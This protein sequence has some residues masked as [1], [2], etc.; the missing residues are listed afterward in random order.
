MIS[1]IDTGYKKLHTMNRR[2]FLLSVAK[3]VLLGGIITRLF[4]LQINENKKYLTLSDKN[5]LR[6]WKLPPTR[7]EFLDYFGNVVAGN[8]KV[9][10]LH[11]V[12]EQVENFKYLMLRLKDIL[13]LNENQFSKI[14]KKK[15]SQKPWETL[16]ISENLT[17]DQFSKVNFYLHELSGAKPVLSVARSY[18]YK[19]NYTHV[20]G[21]VS[22]ASQKDL[23]NNENIKNKHVPGLRVGKTG[24]EKKF[25]NEL[26]G[27][28]GVQRYE[29]NAYGK[30]INQVDFKEGEKGKIIRLTIDTEIQKF[31]NELLADKAGS[32]SVMD[33]FTG[34]II[35]MHSSPSFDPN[36][37]LYGISVENWKSIRENT[38]KPLINKTI[39]GLYSPGSTIKPIVALSALENNVI[40]PNFKV[41]CTG[42]T[43]LYGQTYHCW[44]EKGH[45]VVDLKNA[46]KKSCDTYFYEMSRRLGVD[47][48]NVTATRYGLGNKVFNDL[49]FEEKKG[50]VP[51]TKWK[52]DNL[53][54]G[55]VLGE[56]LITGIGQGYIQT[57][58]LQ[59]CLMTAQLANGGFKI[60]PRLTVE[61]D[62]ESLEKIKYKMSESLKIIEK[63]DSS[64]IRT[65]EKFFKPGEKKYDKLFRNQ[66]NVKFVLDA[67]FASTNEW[68]GTSYRSRIE[69]KKYQ[70]AGKT[71]TAQV[72]KI[73]KQER[74]LDLDTA[75]IPYEQRDH[76]WYIAFGPYKNPRYA[77]SILVEH[78]GAGSAAAAP[79]AKKLF[80]KI[81]DRHEER[82][83]IRKNYLNEI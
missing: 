37:F 76:A 31:C 42:K 47:R 77:L 51:S 80:K 60:F 41:R 58:P 49:Y 43:E 61:K 70:F 36:L 34:D 72:K 14:I 27:T 6:E 67:M 53:G 38:L 79:L 26:I 39:S 19:E 46:I 1:G 64:I 18:P 20:L 11:V 12:P 82:E 5:R 15:N 48:L 25:E 45:G 63:N 7:G 3:V 83:R 62:Q 66:E 9:Y 59:L 56:T 21:Y 54:R 22:Q 69:D 44:K 8:L 73:T 65:A 33:I 74:E 68:G 32:I 2:V 16:I 52:K 78:G 28:N 57:T 23:A 55:W 40:S 71:G 17:W 29:V 24:L 30:R 35:A 10:Q 81:I 50:L 13:E 4:S 75:Q